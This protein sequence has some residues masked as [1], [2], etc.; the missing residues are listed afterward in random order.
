MLLSWLVS[1]VLL[2]NAVGDLGP[3]LSNEEIIAAVI[4]SHGSTGV[5]SKL[6]SRTFGI[7]RETSRSGEA[8]RVWSNAIYCYR[9]GKDLRNSGW[10]MAVISVL[11]VAI[12]FGTAFA[13]LEAVPTYFSCRSLLVI[14][15][16]HSGFSVQ[17]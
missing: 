10:K 6:T 7:D 11:P 2:S 15:P 12:A 1:V 4:S 5:T 13:V 3:A 16:L 9:P 17:P 8:S 14:G